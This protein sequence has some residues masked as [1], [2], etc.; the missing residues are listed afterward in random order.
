MGTLIAPPHSSDV[1]SIR[2]EIF[3]QI[4][5]PAENMMYHHLMEA[6]KD[7]IAVA[8]RD[9]VSGYKRTIMAFN[10]LRSGS[11]NP[12]LHGQGLP[13]QKRDAVKRGR[14]SRVDQDNRYRTSQP[15]R[16]KKLC[17]VCRSKGIT[18]TDH[19]KG[20]KCPFA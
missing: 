2:D 7:V 14:P 12:D 15:L 1:K 6:A 10:A 3:G 20:G 19:R 17:S 8:L 16:K 9:G 4:S 5:V 13:P 11:K 18:A